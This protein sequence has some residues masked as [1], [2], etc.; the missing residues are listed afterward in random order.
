MSLIL[1]ADYPSPDGRARSKALRELGHEVVFFN[2]Q[3]PTVGVPIAEPARMAAREF[4]PF[5]HQL[6]QFLNARVTSERLF[7]ECKR[8][9]P[10]ILLVIKGANLRASVLGRIKRRLKPLVIN[11]F[12][13]SLLTPGIA[14]F[15]ERN[16]D[17]YDFFFVIDDM[18]VLEYVKVRARHVATLP[19][20]CDPA[21]H[22]PPSMGQGERGLYGSPVAFVGTVIPSRERVLEAV[23]EFGLKMWGPPRNPWGTWNPR[24]SGLSTCWQGRSAYGEEA[25]KIYAASDVVLDI[26]F[27]FGGPLPICNV[28]ARLFEVPASGGFLLT[29]ACDQ[30]RQLYSVG[31][32]MVCYRSLEELRRLLAH[33]LARPEE[34]QAIAM[35]A[36][37]RAR[38]EHTFERRLEKMLDVIARKA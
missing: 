33:Y 26:H 23:R 6:S 27:S 30:L 38:S 22:C 34:R 31:T 9:R 4:L 20:A 17:V 13:D 14:K 18:Q 28:T 25:V 11:W 12:G 19:F 10:D 15:V 5:Y 21:F 3:A 7:A 32:E 36:Q 1:L 24:T 37:A 29:N 16:S 8:I 2:T 35:R